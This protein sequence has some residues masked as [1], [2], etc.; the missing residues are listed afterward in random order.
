MR[1]SNDWGYRSPNQGISDLLSA[2]VKS[3]S[4]REDDTHADEPIT[5]HV[6]QA[7]VGVLNRE[8]PTLFE[9]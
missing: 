8:A 4:M 5:N 7:Q 9:S 1:L 6:N 3:G 2:H